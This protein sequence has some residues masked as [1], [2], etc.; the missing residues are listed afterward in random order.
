MRISQ[1]SNSIGMSSL[2]LNKTTKELNKSAQRIASGK[3]LNT[4][5]VGDYGKL[6]TMKGHR[7]TLKVSTEN[8]QSAN[9]FASVKDGALSQITDLAQKISQ[10]YAKGDLDAADTASVTAYTSEITNI[11]KDTEFN[12]KKV[13]S[14]DVIN[15]GDAKLSA[16]TLNA[17]GDD[18]GLEFD[19]AENT[20]ASLTKILSETGTNAAQMNGF[21]AR[22]S[23]NTTMGANLD[24]AISRVEDVDVTE[25]NSKFAQLSIQQQINAAMITNM[26]NMQSSLLNYLI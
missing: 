17:A 19:T 5:L 22:I 1:M 7:N 9:D 18:T 12:G 26:Q 21:D 15:F 25:E 13:F 16:S 24:E 6:N 11:L 20:A 14:K 3:K 23:V 8:L 10:T 4:D 2:Y